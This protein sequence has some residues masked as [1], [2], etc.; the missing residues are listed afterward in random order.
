MPR[1]VQGFKTQ[2]SVYK[3]SLAPTG[4]ARCRQ[5]KRC[6]DKGELR[7]ETCAFV[8]PGRRTVFVQHAACVTAVVAHELLKVYG[9]VERVPVAPEVASGLAEKWLA[10]ITPPACVRS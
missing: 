6:I 7:L 5:C 10:S 4:R 2:P 8:R 3:L 9:T 1:R